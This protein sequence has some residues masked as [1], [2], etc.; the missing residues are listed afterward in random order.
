[1]AYLNSGD[2]ANAISALKGAIAL[3]PFKASLH[4]QLALIYQRLQQTTQAIEALEAGLRYAPQDPTA[5]RMLQDL[6]AR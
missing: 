5:Q 4:F 3:Q 2:T 6:R 1:L